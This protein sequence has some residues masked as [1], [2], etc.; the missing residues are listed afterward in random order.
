MSRHKQWLS[1]G[2]RNTFLVCCLLLHEFS[3]LSPLTC[4]CGRRSSSYCNA[5]T[6][7]QPFFEIS[8]THPSSDSKRKSCIKDSAG[9][10]STQQPSR[11]ED[12]KM[13]PPKKIGKGSA[14]PTPKSE[15]VSPHEAAGPSQSSSIR[16]QNATQSLHIGPQQNLEG[17]A[18]DAE[19]IYFNRPR[20]STHRAPSHLN[21]YTK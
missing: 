18:E 12:S 14:K 2:L 15:P 8:C 21:R 5:T 1:G 10:A 20:P 19:G 13:P 6:P 17:S 7:C 11:L 16:M 9:S 4:L 3:S